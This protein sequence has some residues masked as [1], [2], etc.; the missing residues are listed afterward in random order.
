MSCIAGLALVLASPGILL[1]QDSGAVR[2]SRPL[3]T[4][5]INE[6]KLQTLAG[7][8]HPQANAQNDAGPAPDS[9]P[10]GPVAGKLELSDR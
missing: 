3:I 1:S 8:T 10:P 9:L 2:H 4:E 6:A 7:N 5:R